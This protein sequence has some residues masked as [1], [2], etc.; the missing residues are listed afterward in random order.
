M[1]LE[2]AGAALDAVLAS[3]VEPVDAGEARALIVEMEGLR[4][5]ADAA[6][7]S[8]QASIQRRGLHRADG[9]RSAKAM[10]RHVARLSPAEAAARARWVDALAELPSVDSAYAAGVLP[11]CALDRIGRLHANPRVRYALP[12]IEAD[13]VT[14]AQTLPAKRFEAKVSQWERLIDADGTRDANQRHHANRDAG[15]V[16][17]VDRSGEL[18]A[19]WGAYQG[20]EPGDLRMPQL[21]DVLEVAT[22]RDG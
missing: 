15:L 9:H 3:G 12:R 8:L 18:T 21:C 7:L 20:A 1:E 4:R 11:T 6:A 10:V 14:A 2:R 16:Q 17:P 22:G 5:R 19:G 13:L